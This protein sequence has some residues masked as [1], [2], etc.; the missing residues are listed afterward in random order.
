[1]LKKMKKK[2]LTFGLVAL[3]TNGPSEYRD[4]TVKI[5][6]ACC[7][8]YP[9]CTSGTERTCRNSTLS[10]TCPSLMARWSL[11]TCFANQ[12]ESPSPARPC[13]TSPALFRLRKARA[14]DPQGYSVSCK[15]TKH[16]LW[17]PLQRFQTFFF[18]RISTNDSCCKL[19]QPK[20]I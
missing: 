16:V 15:M 4:V 13:K 18:F 20:N 6:D 12:T 14:L 1:M 19:N 7:K 10:G 11:P 8:L 17:L 3:R 2:T 9:N 5:C